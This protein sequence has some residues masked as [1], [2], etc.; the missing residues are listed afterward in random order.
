MKIPKNWSFKTSDVAQNFD[1]HVREQLP[2]YDL[3]TRL[4][5]HI[6]RHYIGEN[7]IVYDIGA[8]T[9]NIGLALEESIVSRQA[10]IFAVEESSQ[11]A[12]AFR[13]CKNSTLIVKDATKIEYEP[14][15]FCVCFLSLLFLR[16]DERIELLERLKNATKYGGAIVVFDR[17][18]PSSGYVGIIKTRLALIEKINAGATHK[19]ILE[20]EL[21]LMGIQRPISEVEL[22]QDAIEIFRFGDFAGWIIERTTTNK[23][24]LKIDKA[25]P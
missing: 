14:F 9:G 13:P 1:S 25:N 18:T 12:K 16:P 4:V 24:I 7:G 19:A 23:Q 2:W 6:G 11:M 8:S 3:A 5:A 17:T 21:S 15:D 20:K 10:K 22:G